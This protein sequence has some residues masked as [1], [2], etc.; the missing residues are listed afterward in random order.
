MSQ[1]CI[2]TQ[3]NIHCTLEI[4]DKTRKKNPEVFKGKLIIQVAC[5]EREF[6]ECLEK[7]M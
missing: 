6:S 2:K 5:D 3:G 4:S 7:N 1:E